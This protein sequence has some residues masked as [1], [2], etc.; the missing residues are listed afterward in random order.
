MKTLGRIVILVICLLTHRGS[1]QGYLTL[2]G[3]PFHTTTF[4][5]PDKGLYEVS[6]LINQCNYDYDP[7]TF[8]SANGIIPSRVSTVPVRYISFCVRKPEGC[9][10]TY[11]RTRD[12]FLDSFPINNKMVVHKILLRDPENHCVKVGAN[13]I[14][15][16]LFV[17]KI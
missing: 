17:Y 1:A 12:T 8:T 15:I 7:G 9:I 13:Y 4:V 14:N 10:R 3:S 11:Y 16:V 6:N 2:M 5:D